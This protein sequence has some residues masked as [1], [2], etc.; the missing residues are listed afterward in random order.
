MI[1]DL[2][3]SNT[4]FFRDSQK[5]KETSQSIYP[6]WNYWDKLSVED[7]LIFKTFKL[8]IPTPKQKDFLKDLQ[9]CHLGEEKTQRSPRICILARNSRRYQAVHQEM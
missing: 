9:V 1:Q 3:K 6:F 8:V 2:A 4:R 7:G 5:P